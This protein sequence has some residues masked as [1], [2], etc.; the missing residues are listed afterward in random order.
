MTRAVIFGFR[1]VLWSAVIAASLGMATAQTRVG[2]IIV[3]GNQRIPDATVI[4]LTEFS[5][6]QSVSN[7]QISDAVQRI[8]ASGLFETVD[9]RPA[10]GGLQ[11]TVVER[12]TVNRISIE[13]N[14]RLDDEELLP[15]VTLSPRRVYSAQQAEADANAI[16]QSYAN[17]ARLSAVVT[18]R[19]IRR[20][21]NRVDVVFEVSEARVVENERISFVGNRV[22]SDR[23]L[24]RV[25]VTKQA[26]LFRQI[27][28][29]DPFV[30]ERIAF[31]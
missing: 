28:S 27:I 17:R 14:R 10:R 13:G 21:D 1:A 18:P 3:D 7:D 8:M 24:R 22:F 5:P 23:R 31:D 4:R 30:P 20:S 25:I 29:R 2:T 11:V 26:S 16:A 9:V 15:F 6:G 19:I 12:P